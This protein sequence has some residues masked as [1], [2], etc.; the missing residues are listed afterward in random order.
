MHILETEAKGLFDAMRNFP[1]TSRRQIVIKACQRIVTSEPD[2]QD[3]FTDIDL[4]AALPDQTINALSSLAEE[5]DDI[6]L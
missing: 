5:A 2:L 6:Y 3:L 4:N 1:A